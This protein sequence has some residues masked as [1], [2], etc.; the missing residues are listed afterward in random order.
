M[1]RVAKRTVQLFL[2][3]AL[4]LL[5]TS[6]GA[7]DLPTA[8]E[9]L[10]KSLE[11]SGGR[12]AY[13][14]VTSQVTK[15][16]LEIVG[17]GM[18]ADITGYNDGKNSRQVI[19]IPGMG[20]MQEGCNGEIAWTMD[21]MMG[22]RLLKGAERAFAVRTASLRAPLEI[23]K[24]YKEK[25]CEGVEK[26]GDK[27]CYKLAM[28]PKEGKVEYWFID[29]ATHLAVRTKVTIQSAMGEIESV[30]DMSDYREV[31][32]LKIPFTVNIQ[33]GMQQLKVVTS[34]VEH[35]VE[36]PAEKTALPAEIKALVDKEKA[37]E[38]GKT[39]EEKKE[40]KKEGASVGG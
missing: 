5:G 22:P 38:A 21:A 29:K 32:G 10:E 15:A 12:E 20:E 8:D 4:A 16:T 34:K 24:H 30:I 35:N 17:A 31:G 7:E 6:I 33:Q 18:T 13:E 23:D 37:K 11:A 25:K 26:V 39:G 28:T 2:V 14:K 27:D 36:V 1:T 19:N 3:A 9:V 40:E